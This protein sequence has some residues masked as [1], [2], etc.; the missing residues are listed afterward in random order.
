M[1]VLKQYGRRNHLPMG[2]L[3]AVVGLL[4]ASGILGAQGTSTVTTPSDAA[5]FRGFETDGSSDLVRSQPPDL[6]QPALYEAES[7]PIALALVDP[8]G[9]DVP[10]FVSGAGTGVSLGSPKT[11][12]PEAM[13]FPLT[14]TGQQTKRIL[15]IMP[16]F[17]AVSANT[18]LPPLSLR[19]K[20]WL[21]TENTFDYSSFDLCRHAGCDRAGQ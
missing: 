11:P 5:A 3:F 16:N 19:Q 6:L 2:R 21:A 13:R 17:D 1:T 7:Q 4:S 14:S 10:D 9:G 15:G 8:I 12:L 20:F 18:H